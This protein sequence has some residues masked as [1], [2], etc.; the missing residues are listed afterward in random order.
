[1]SNVDGAALTFHLA[2]GSPLQTYDAHFNHDRTFGNLSLEALGVLPGLD[3]TGFA[4]EQKANGV[5]DS[6]QVGAEGLPLAAM[7]GATLF[8]GGAKGYT[9]YPAWEE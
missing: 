1:M 6:R 2:A 8:G 3:L 5:L 9:D 4:F 7:D